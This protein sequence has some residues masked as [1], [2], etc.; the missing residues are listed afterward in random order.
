[1]A[2]QLEFRRALDADP[3]LRQ[4]FEACRRVDSLLRAHIGPGA[5]SHISS[6]DTL[7]ERA[8]QAWD[9]ER[10]RR[11]RPRGRFG[12]SGMLL[13]S[14]AALSAAAAALVL[15]LAPEAPNDGCPDWRPPAFVPLTLRGAGTS[16]HTQALSRQV[17]LR[18]Q[19]TLAQAL[20]RALDVR[21]VALP[22]DWTATLRMH[23]LPRGAF[24]VTVQVQDS[25]VRTIAEWSGTYSNADAFLNQV[26]ASA[27][28]MAEDLAA[29]AAARQRQQGAP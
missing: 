7:A 1:M 23:E 11:A 2:S 4:R 16:E 18:C 6:A 10:L 12:W 13:K 8:M 24:S 21:A 17:A 20:D 19:A 3:T 9:C 28:H 22:R 14:A 27:G 15:W 26:D 5:A 29:H 25:D